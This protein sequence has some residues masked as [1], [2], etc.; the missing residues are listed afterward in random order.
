MS[1]KTKTGFP[2]SAK[3]TSQSEIPIAVAVPIYV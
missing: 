2:K 1:N 3:V